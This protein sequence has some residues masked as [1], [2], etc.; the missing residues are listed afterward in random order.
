MSEVSAKS[1]YLATLVTA[2]LAVM[3]AQVAYS[4]P[5]ALNGTFQQVFNTAGSQLTWI[6]AAFA[7]PMVIFELTSGVVGDLFGRKRLLQ[8]GT[9]LV[10]AGALVSLVAHD[11]HVMW[12]GQAVS[13]LGAGVLFPISLAMIAAAAPTTEARSRAIALWAGF[14]SIGAA[15]SPLLAGLFAKYG[16]WRGSY[17]VVVAAAL[18]TCLLAFAAADSS[19]PEGRRLDLPGQLTLALGLFAILYA[20]VQGSEKG[21]GR[22]EIVGAFVVGAALLVAFVVI[23]LRTEVPLLHLD[24]F[25]NRA[26]TVSGI[27][28]VVGMFSFLGICFSMSIWMGAVQHQSALKIGVLFL[29][30]QGPAFVLVP[31]VSHLIRNVS[32][33]WVL[34]AGFALIAVAGIWC[35][36]FDVQDASWTRFIPPLLVLGVGFALTVGSITAVAINTVPVRLAGM[37]SA[38]TNLLRDLGFALGPVVVGAVATSAANGRLMDGLGAVVGKLTGSGALDQAHAGAA[39]GI[40]QQGGAIAL[41]SLP[42]IPGQQPVPMP[43]ELHTLALESLGHAYGLAFLVCGL[44]AAGSAALTLVGLVGAKEPATD[45][46]PLLEVAGV[47]GDVEVAS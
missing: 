38:T 2:C 14:L 18:I 20:A 28:A 7:I 42:V 21:W 19:A 26:F 41:N 25:K 47:A 45:I 5:G 39:M 24:L 32:P 6:S 1:R 16:S 36:T 12:V 46:D 31:V 17:V 3:V 30:I 27:V 33:R 10:V 34:T 13:G 44:C 22:P 29:F 9:L 4:L 8:G 35:S 23:E 37:A 43:A 15:L 11:V 40:S